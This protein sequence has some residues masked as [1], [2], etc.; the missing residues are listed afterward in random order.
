MGLY[1]RASVLK[2]RV[3]QTMLFQIKS[4]LQFRWHSKN[5]HAVHSPFIFTLI[6]K[7]FYDK[8][9]KPEYAI[10]KEYRNSLLENKNSIEVTDFGAGSK[11]FKSNKR[12]ISKIAKT[13]GIT[14]KRAELLFRIVNYFELDSILEI[15]TSL[16]LATAA[17]SLGNTNAKITTLE[18]CPE[19]AK[20][21]Q[22]QFKKF[23]FK[24]INS[25]VSEFTSYLEKWKLPL[26]TK[27]EHYNLNTEHFSL[28]YFDGN[29]Q[30]QA[31][32]DYFELLLPTITNETVWIFDDIHWSK[33]MEEAWEIIKNHQKVTVTID[34]FQ[35]GLVF[36]RR[37]QPKEHFIIRV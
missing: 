11:V 20:V 9:P 24:N 4:Y 16:G 31:T 32:L 34:T 15:G 30:K 12:E 2:L 5:E 19:T 8:K 25:V 36:F 6:T 14:G 13:A 17:L 18:G 3:I 29:H 27:T 37:E 35:W 33:E 7:C 10:L 21:A 28:I 22:E 23:N 1:L 26:N